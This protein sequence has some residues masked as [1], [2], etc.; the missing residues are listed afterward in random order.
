MFLRA[1]SFVAINGSIERWAHVRMCAG[2]AA[3]TDALFK[4]YGSLSQ[5]KGP[6]IVFVG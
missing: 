6:H 1:H 2:S 5:G 3:A 4:S